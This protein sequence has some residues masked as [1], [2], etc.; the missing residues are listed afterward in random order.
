MQNL[1]TFDA[2]NQVF[3]LSNENI[4]YLFSL[5]EGG[6]LSH[7]YFGK[8]ISG[9]HGQFKYPRLDR[10]FS[11]NL[12]GSLDRTYSLDSLLQEYSTEGVGDYRVLASIIE[13]EDG[14]LSSRFTYQK[15]E[16]IAGK[17]KLAGLPAAYVEDEN[18][19]QTLIVTLVDEVSQV[20]LELL[21]TIYATRDVITRSVKVVNAGDK[22][23]TLQ[24]IASMQLDM[25]K[26]DLEVISLPG[27]HVN[28][29]NIQREKV[30]YGIK[31]FASRRG[32]TSHQMNNF[33]A[34]VSPKTTEFS[35][36]AYGFDMVYS[37]NHSFEIQKDQFEQYRLVAGIN[38]EKFAWK[39]QPNESFQTPEIVMVYAENGLNQMSQTYHALIS[40]RIVRG[41]HKYQE[42][43][44][45]VNNWEATYFDFDEA[46]LR[47]IVDEAKKLGIEMFVLDDGWFGKRDDDNSSLGDWHVDQR[48]FPEGLQGFANYVHQQ[49]LKFGL[50]FEPE[51]IS[52]E[53]KLYQAHPDYM[54]KVPNRQASPARNQYV[55][56]MGRKEVRQNIQAQMEALLDQGFIDYIKWDMNRHLSDVYAA[57]LPADCQGKVM[58]RYVLGLYELLE[59][60]TTK[61]PNILWEGCSGGGGRFDSGFAYYMPQSWTSDNTDAVARLKIQYGTSLVYPISTMTSHLSAVPNHQTG[62]ITPFETR[63]NMA[64]SAVF[65]Y[66]LNLTHMTDEEKQQVKQQ[67]AFYKSIRQLVQFGTFIRLKS[68][69]EQNEVA[70]MFVAKDQK[71]ALLFTFNILSHAQPGFKYTK[72]AGL[73][74]E[75][76][77]QNVETGEVYYGDELMNIGLYQPVAK[78]DFTSNY[79]HFKAL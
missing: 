40:D 52:Y 75:Q 8:K 69:F 55:L 20:K 63:G 28:E 24:K 56:D 51:M 45:L 67:V 79:Y 50:W 42:R 23:V 3:N 64:M 31:K 53:S 57:D 21:Y 16:I 37:G 17:P 22:S 60:L 18:E 41:K 29:R 2:Q 11:G 74:P 9:Y 7:L 4:S 78:Q 70:W 71:E 61:Y 49:G 1:I 44:I 65:G 13:H 34:L 54:L 62:R 46:K 32:T 5:E 76:Q 68:P 58:H 36:E 72:L 38:E 43:P 47:P 15:H 35:G 6:I 66:E 59:N 27:A 25:I 73:L 30:G 26:D 14:S 19:A 12:P 33:V 10:G 77:Y 39:L 48:K